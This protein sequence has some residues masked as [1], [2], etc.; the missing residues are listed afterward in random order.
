MEM[1]LEEQELGTRA[2]EG[3]ATFNAA[4]H[5]EMFRLALEQAGDGIAM[6]N[7]AGSFV[8]MNQRHATM[9]GYEHKDAL[10]DQPWS[11]LYPVEEA[12]RMVREVFPLLDAP[13]K[14]WRGLAYGVSRQ[15]KS[16]R[17]EV[18]LTILNNGGILCITRDIGARIDADAQRRQLRAELDRAQRLQTVGVLASGLGHDLGN[19]LTA[20]IGVVDTERLERAENSATIERLDAMRRWLDQAG[21]LA[22]RLHRLGAAPPSASPRTEMVAA[23]ESAA[24]LMR[25]GLGI[26]AEIRLRTTD[27]LAEVP[28]DDTT[29]TQI[30]VNLIVNARDAS[31]QGAAIDVEVATIRAPAGFSEPFAGRLAGGV[32]HTSVGAMPAGESVLLR[33][34]DHGAGVAPDTLD[35][36]LEPFFTTKQRGKGSGLGLPMAADAVKDAGGLLQL[37]SIEG[38]GTEVRVWLPSVGSEPEDWKPEGKVL[39]CM[40]DRDLG[41]VVDTTLRE[42]GMTAHFVA[43]FHQLLGHLASSEATAALVIELTTIPEPTHMRLATIRSLAPDRPLLIITSADQ[44]CQSDRRWQQYADDCLVSPFS[45][46]Q[47]IKKLTNIVADRS[48]NECMEIVS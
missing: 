10:L 1:K 15:G 43:S 12:E 34:T 6:T 3:S 44:P 27:A 7:A 37:F 11:V 38:V 20:I 39:V 36:V 48:G 28:L 42:A 19:I 23:V 9:F 25:S 2:G 29:V 33:V 31:P 40:A 13:G 41:E 26:K 24:E 47:L 14:R 22:R 45:A 8:F 17:Q 4:A 46:A 35:R 16:V 18:S 32:P 21:D 30:F 5:L